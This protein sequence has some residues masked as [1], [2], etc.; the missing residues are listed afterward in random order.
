MKTSIL[1]I[2]SNI[3]SGWFSNDILREIWDAVHLIFKENLN[4]YQN[5][6]P[7]ILKKGQKRIIND[8]DI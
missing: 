4:W 2:F 7:T 6:I 8:L 5:T 1:K 3:T